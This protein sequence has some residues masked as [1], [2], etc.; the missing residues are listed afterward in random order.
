MIFASS[1]NS[2]CEIVVEFVNVRLLSAET[3][4]ASGAKTLT[5]TVSTYVSTLIKMVQND[6]IAIDL[7]NCLQQNIAHR[8]QKT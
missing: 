3:V 5:I 6:T 8:Y 7:L 4:A 1:R 2:S